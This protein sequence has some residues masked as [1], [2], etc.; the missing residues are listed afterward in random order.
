MNTQSIVDGQF[1]AIDLFCGAG[2]VSQ[3]MIQSDRVKI[4][5]AV[6]HSKEAI[7][8]HKKSNPDVLH[9]TEDIRDTERILPNMPTKCGI[10]WASTECTNY[11]NAK[12]GQSR[13]QDSRTLPEHL[14]PYVIHCNPDYFI[15]ENIKEFMQWGPLEPKT[16]KKGKVMYNKDGSIQLHPTKLYRGTLYRNWVRSICDLG[17]TYNYQLLNSADFG[18]HTARTRYFGVFA[19]I[20]LPISFPIPTHAKNPGMFGEKKWKA[21]K[22]KINLDDEGN[23]IFGRKRNK[24]IAKHLRRPLADK[25]LARIAYGLQKYH[26]DD[27]IAKAF[28]T[29]HNVSS[30]DEPLHTIDCND[31]H[32]KVSVDKTHHIDKPYGFAGRKPSNAVGSVDKPLGTITTVPGLSIVTCEKGRFISKQQFGDDQVSCIEHPLH[33][34]VTKCRQQLVT[35]EN[36]SYIVKQQGQLKGRKPTNAVSSTD[37]PLHT[38]MTANRHNIVQIDGKG[39]FLTQPFHNTNKMASDIDKPLGTIITKDQKSIVTIDKVNFICKKNPGKANVQST[40]EPLHTIMTK[41]DKAL[42]TAHKASF[43]CKKNSGKHQVQSIDEPLHTI[44]TGDGK[45]VI[46]VCLETKEDEWIHNEKMRFFKKYFPD[47]DPTLLCLIINDIKMR[48]LNSEELADITG[49]K[50]GTYL[51]KNEKVRKKHIGNAVPPIIPQ[52][53]IQELWNVSQSNSNTQVA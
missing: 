3:G 34:I 17:Y 44:M 18:A 33:T 27:F 21:C 2:G 36:K 30:M 1:T 9:L 14:P 29:Q 49:F 42:I 25:T 53:M 12:G 4:L 13:D 22:E 16:D 39:Y 23:S 24:N 5:V 48:Y 51:G 31:R 32:A 38:I 10:L 52:V 43:I 46:T 50:K 7:E 35:A 26:L 19:K 47:H 11:S 6:N 45:F 8:A 20:G 41:D 40:D 15:I 37:E 28:N